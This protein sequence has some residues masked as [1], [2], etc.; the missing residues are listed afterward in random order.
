MQQSHQTPSEPIEFLRHLISK[1]TDESLLIK[2]DALIEKIQNSNG[3]F[4]DVLL[5]DA[6]NN[7]A[8]IFFRFKPLFLAMKTISNN[9]TFFNQLR[10][11]ANK[12]H[13]PM[14]EDYFNSV[15]SRIKK[16]NLDL[17]DFERK[18]EHTNVFRKIRLANA[19]KYRIHPKESI[20]YRVRNG[21]GWA[22]SFDWSNNLKK[23]TKQ[24]LD[25]VIG[26]IV[27]DIYANVNGKTF[28]IPPN[29]HYT[30]P[31]T[32]KQFT[33]N[34]PTGSYITVSEDLIV[35]IHWMNTSRRIDLDLSVIG[36]S[37]KIGWDAA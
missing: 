24:A 8:S 13:L 7:L 11:K 29:I 32:E 37:G 5:Q 6:P 25:I 20:V 14:P 19:L 27:D 16:G 18:L 10:K 23:I 17:N 3:K 33:G 28:Y 26:S 1:L 36:E 30:L 9:K 4:L 2:N 35:G 15:T 31:A 34:L 12:L 21:R 22:T